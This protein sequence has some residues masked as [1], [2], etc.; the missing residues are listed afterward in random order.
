MVCIVKIHGRLFGDTYMQV[1]LPPPPSVLS[2]AQ[3]LLTGHIDRICV[4]VG[5]VLFDPTVHIG[6]K[7]ACTAHTIIE[8]VCGQVSQRVSVPF[9]FLSLCPSILDVLASDWPRPFEYARGSQ[10][11]KRSLFHIMYSSDSSWH[12]SQS[13]WLQTRSTLASLPSSR[14][15]K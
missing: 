5:H 14:P 10:R 8:V 3:V 15:S 6:G 13:T 2:D 7:G 4:S 1:S 12:L 11:C 9:Q